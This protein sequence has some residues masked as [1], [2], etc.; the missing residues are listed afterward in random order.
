MNDSRR[1]HIVFVYSRSMPYPPSVDNIKAYYVSQEFVRRGA[2]VTWLQIGDVP[3]KWEED[4]IEFVKMGSPAHRLIR[5]PIQLIQMIAFCRSTDVDCVYSDEWLF[6]R[7]DLINRLLFQIGLKIL[8]VRYALDQRDP[9]VDYEIAKGN[10]KEGS[11]RHRRLELLNNLALRLTDLAIFP[12]ET[13]ADELRSRGLPAK[14]SIGTIRG[15]DDQQFNPQVDGSTI[16]SSLGLNDK[17]VVGWFGMMTHYR[18]L[19]EVVIPLIEKA[20]DFIPDIHFLIG[21]HG[22]LEGAFSRLKDSRPD[23]GMTVLGFVPYPRL[24]EHLAAC[25]VLLGPLNTQ[26]RLI[27]LTSPLKIMESL[28]VGR[29]IIATETKVSKGDYRDLAG[30]VWTGGD[31]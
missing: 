30:V 26:Y 8:G 6:F 13:Y 25:D 7:G 3:A 4:G 1:F 31:Y 10:L 23:L 20:R 22:D 11:W 19:E 17:F 16:R 27:S 18:Q 12:S 28:A 21:G 9:F 14:N 5:M 29:P 24:P 2:K 15:V